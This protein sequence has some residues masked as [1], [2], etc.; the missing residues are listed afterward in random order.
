MFIS[1]KSTN[2]QE[3]SPFMHFLDIFICKDTARSLELTG[4]LPGSS[5]DNRLMHTRGGPEKGGNRNKARGK[6]TSSTIGGAIFNMW[7]EAGHNIPEY[8]VK[9]KTF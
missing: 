7:K 4:A 3:I 9:E 5:R 1:T 6:L 2:L 8:L